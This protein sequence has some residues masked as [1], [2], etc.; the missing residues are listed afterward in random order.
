MFTNVYRDGM[1]VE[2]RHV[3]KRDLGQYLPSFVWDRSKIDGASGDHNDILG[4]NRTSS[5]SFIAP[6]G[7]PEIIDSN[8]GDG[9]LSSTSQGE[10]A[11]TISNYLDSQRPSTDIGDVKARP[12]FVRQPSGSALLERQKANGY[13]AN[14]EALSTRSL[15]GAELQEHKERVGSEPVR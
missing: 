1:K 9:V 8:G 13:G 4:M 7:V 10:A 2:A 5:A 15:P 11:N 12:M 14:S 3:K 6:A